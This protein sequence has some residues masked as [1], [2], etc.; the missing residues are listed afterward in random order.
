[1]RIPLRTMLVPLFV[2]GACSAAL[3]AEEKADDK[4]G[5]SAIIFVVLLPFMLFI[6]WLVILARKS[7]KTQADY[8][9]TAR[10]HIDRSNEHMARIEQK[11]D[12]MIELLESIDEHLR[13]ADA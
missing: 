2:I 9:V 1:M 10:E 8:M 7:T 6:G 12:R 5:S 11:T 4:S 3:A 13:T